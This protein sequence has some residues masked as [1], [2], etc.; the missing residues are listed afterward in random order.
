MTPTEFT[1]SLM[2]WLCIGF[3]IGYRYHVLQVRDAVARR[4]KRI[5]ELRRERALDRVLAD[6]GVACI[7]RPTNVRTN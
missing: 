4:T 2:L 6:V 7:E 5:V 1:L 3:L